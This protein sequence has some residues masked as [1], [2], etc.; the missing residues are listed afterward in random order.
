MID[1]DALLA[2]F[3]EE[4]QQ[5]LQ[6]IEPDLLELE[7]IGDAIDSETLNRIFRSVHSIKGA[8]GFFGLQKI[9][10]LSH[11]MESLL[12][13]LRDR[14]ITVFR[15]LTDALLAGVDTLRA[16]VDDVAGSENTDIGSLVEALREM[17]DR[18]KSGGDEKTVSLSPTAPPISEN[19][20]PKTLVISEE[21]AKRFLARGK[22]IYSVRI[23]L[24]EDLQAKNRTPYDYINEMERLGQFVDSFLDINQVQ[25]L[26]DCLR[27]ELAFNF[28]FATVLDPD[29]V[30]V[31]LE[32]PEE[33]IT[34][35][36]LEQQMK[37]AVKETVP[38]VSDTAA[39]VS[40]VPLP[41]KAEE[42]SASVS[43]DNQK[44]TPADASD[45]NQ[46]P[47]EKPQQ[48]S[49][50]GVRAVQTEDKLRVGVNLLNDLVNLAGELVL[51]RNQLMETSTPLIKQANG[52]NAVLQHVSRITTEMQEKVMQLRMQPVSVIFGKF[53]RIVRDMSRNLQ[54]D[55]V[56]ETHG[57]EVELD[58]SIIE[59]LSDPLTHLIRNSADHGIEAPDIRERA[60]KP[61][62]GKIVLRAY[63]EGGQVHLAI[64]DDGKGI[65]PAVVGKKAVENGLVT[66]Q[67]LAAMS[68]KDILKLIFRPGFSTAASVTSVSGRGVGMD[69]VRTNIERLGGTVEIETVAGKGTTMELVLP[70]TLAIVS[71]LVVKMRDQVY[72]LPEVNIEEM[73]RIKPD[74]VHDRIN[75]VQNA[76]VLRLRDM[77]V[78]LVD[79]RDV[80]LGKY[81]GEKSIAERVQ[82]NEPIRILI[83]RYG[84]GRFGLIVDTVENMEEIV[85]KP[86]PQYIKRMK[87]FSGATIM[88]NGRVAL[89]LDVGGLVDKAAIQ[90]YEDR[91]DDEAAPQDNSREG[92]LQNLLLFDNGTEERFALPLEL[93]TRIE[94]VPI[95]QIEKVRD[96]HILQYQGEN[97]RLLFLED[98]LPV[99]RPQ[100]N[101]D[102]RIGVIVP[103]HVRHP[104]GI[105][106]N[107]AIDT[108]NAVVK[109]DTSTIM[110]PGLFGTAVIAGKVTLF[111]DMYRLFEIAAPEWYSGATHRKEN[112]KKRILLVEDTPFFRM[113]ESEYLES[114]GYTVV[115]AENGERALSLL[116]EQPFD[117]MVLDII[118]PVLDGWGVIKKVREDPRWNKLPVIAVTSL[119][120]E[121]TAQRGIEAGFSD[122]EIKLNKTRLLE[123]LSG[124]ISAE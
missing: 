75:S 79:L 122:W 71:G 66:S 90:H 32:I 55:I 98:H 78:P 107:R 92:D 13:L 48:K 25:G 64:S 57:E 67:Q 1:E 24:H 101:E 12:S 41:A 106:I 4:S 61:R 103:K 19:E 30:P 8:S 23:L 94:R 70:L 39:S 6:T 20:S 5:H 102:D 11:A 104:M 91:T 110:S 86:L 74:E 111:P 46:S 17:H 28:L 65:D 27:N 97:L 117:A 123:K 34:V 7:K 88:G 93:I 89:I 113:I 60:G 120:D 85:V 9:G 76:Q 40:P 50:R 44:E 16:M 21:N 22:Y 56:L 26:D 62:Q 69:V 81:T 63:H 43:G 73:V 84:S 112:E 118:M 29:L 52:L 124:L 3:V 121:E 47:P 18:G 68:E 100:R 31:A 49:E 80:L 99:T 58:K 109:L 45:H 82:G 38:P 83:L 87:C 33:R 54:K 108:V 119:G 72:I 35:Y 116:A 36:D 105:V 115:Q 10:E 77:I 37:P 53:H 2:G 114:A 59:S 14:K 96:K 51:G 95:S 15:E 42:Y